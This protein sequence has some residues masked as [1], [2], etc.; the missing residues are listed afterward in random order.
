MSR[1][2]TIIIIFL[3]NINLAIGQVISGVVI[4]EKNGKTIEYANIGI[5]GRNIGTVSDYQ[6]KFTIDI[7]S[8]F[9]NDT[10]LVSSIGYFPKEI[11]V[12]ELRNENIKVALK[13]KVYEIKPVVVKPKIYKQKTLGVTTRFRRIIAGFKDNL[14]GYEMGIMMKVKKSA[15]IKS[16]NLNLSVCAYDSLFYRL[17]I[18]K[19]I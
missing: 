3:L 7:N 11:K 18:Y 9:D 1:L 2:I 14:L 8:Q 19:D 10:L 15:R 13:E 16:V 17:N 6:G 4:N 5:V 12:S